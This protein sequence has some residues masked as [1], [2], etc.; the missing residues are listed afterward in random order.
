L[1]RGEPKR[2]ADLLA[3]LLAREPELRAPLSRDPDLGAL[4]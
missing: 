2:A 4:L 3:E 1:G